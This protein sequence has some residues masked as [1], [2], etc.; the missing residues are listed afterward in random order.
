MLF[1]FD[2]GI[3]QKCG[4]NAAIVYE[5]IAQGC[6][7]HFYEDDPQFL[8]EGR[9]WIRASVNQMHE[10]MRYLSDRQIRDALDRLEAAHLIAVDNLN[11]DKRD[12]TKW[13]TL[14]ASTTSEAGHDIQSKQ[15]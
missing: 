8:R 10:D 15:D 14:T 3:A 7:A 5:Y 9:A 1:N 11:E 6:A 12:R 13:Y 2:V 4:L